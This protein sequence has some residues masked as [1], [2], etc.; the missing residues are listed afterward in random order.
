VKPAVTWDASA[1]SHLLSRTSFGGTPKQAERFAARPLPDIVETLIE[2]A[3]RAAAPPKP[4]WVKE[5]WV[6]TERVYPETTPAERMEN[7]RKAGER[8]TKLR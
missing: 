5:P 2:D 3:K 6:N 7:H 8:H 1:A 4:A